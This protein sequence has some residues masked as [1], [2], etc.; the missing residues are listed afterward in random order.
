MHPTVGGSP[1]RMTSTALQQPFLAVTRYAFGLAPTVS[2]LLLCLLLAPVQQLI[3]QRP[4]LEAHPLAEIDH[5][6]T[7]PTP[8]EFAYLCKTDP[9]QALEM[10]LVRYE[11]EITEYRCLMIKKERIKKKENPEEEILCSFREKPFSVLMAWKKGINQAEASLYV[12]GENNNTLQVRPAGLL[13]RNFVVGLRTDDPQVTSTSRYT[14]QEF[15]LER[16]MRR[17]FTAW[18]AIREQGLLKFDY[19]GVQTIKEVGN[20]PCHVIKRFCNP[21]EEDGMTDITIMLD[22]ETW[23]QVGSLLKAGDQL[24]GHYYFREINTNP[25][26]PPGHFLPERLPK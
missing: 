17:T 24:I 25:E 22:A 4:Q 19:Q 16:G 3:H 18:K 11:K 21:P 7:L 10:A 23:L 12:E 14:V 20:R 13:K 8:S 1:L 26:F 15:G 9:I 5:A 2:L 6:K